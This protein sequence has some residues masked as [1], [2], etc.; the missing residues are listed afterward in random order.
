MNKVF[1]NTSVIVVAHYK[2]LNVA[3]M[4]DLRS[5]VKEAG[6]TIKVSKNRLAKLALQGIES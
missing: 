5:K 6:A 2:G 1:T 3:E 4:T